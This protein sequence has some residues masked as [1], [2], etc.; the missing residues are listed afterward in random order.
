[1]RTGRSGPWLPSQ[2]PSPPPAPTISPH[3]SPLSPRRTEASGRGAS[4]EASLL[5]EN[6]VLWAV[7]PKSETVPAAAEPPLDG[8]QQ[9]T[10][11]R[12]YPEVQE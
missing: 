10:S 5:R 1:M 12:Q 3:G 9:P 7:A 4:R 11:G 2:K 6:R 8:F